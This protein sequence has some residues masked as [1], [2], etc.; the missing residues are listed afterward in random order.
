LPSCCSSARSNVTIRETCVGHCFGNPFAEAHVIQIYSLSQIRLN[1]CIQSGNISSSATTSSL[2][3]SASTIQ[4]NPNAARSIC[5]IESTWKRLTCPFTGATAL[6]QVTRPFTGATALY[7]AIL[8]SAKRTH[9]TLRA[10]HKHVLSPSV[11]WGG[12][13]DT[14]TEAGAVFKT[15]PRNGDQNLLTRHLLRL[16]ASPSASEA[17]SRSL[18]ETGALIEFPSRTLDLQRR[19]PTSIDNVAR[20]RDHT[21]CLA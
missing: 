14:F 15:H 11:I 8:S 13:R 16:T 18:T 2:H 17:F 4:P 21:H 19:S 20:M 5:W 10:A 1:Q 9:R 6:Y 7:R 12:F 3:Y